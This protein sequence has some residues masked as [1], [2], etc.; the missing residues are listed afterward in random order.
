M[1][2]P[3]SPGTSIE[4]KLFVCIVK[5]MDPYGNILKVLYRLDASSS[6]TNFLDG[7]HCDWSDGAKYQAANS[8]ENDKKWNSGKT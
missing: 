3:G 2:Q 4:E 7:A 6:L 5:I 1:K 8:A